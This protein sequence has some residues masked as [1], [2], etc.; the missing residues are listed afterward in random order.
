[1][2][3]VICLVLALSA[4]LRVAGAMKEQAEFAAKLAHQA[5]HDDL[6]GLPNRTLIVN[7]VNMLQGQALMYRRARGTDVPRP[8]S[9]QA[10]QRLHGTRDR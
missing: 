1:M 7:Q 2:T 10:R 4:M 3:T 6:T 5:T 9:V 8:R